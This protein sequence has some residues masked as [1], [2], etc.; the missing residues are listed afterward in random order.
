MTNSI[1]FHC[2]IKVFDQS[3]DELTVFVL[4]P[5][6]NQTRSAREWIKDYIRDNCEE[7]VFPLLGIKGVG[8]WEA[9]FVGTIHST[10]SGCLYQEHD[11]TIELEKW[12]TQ[13]LPSEMFETAEDTNLLAQPWIK[14]LLVKRFEDNLAR[15]PLDGRSHPVTQDQYDEAKKALEQPDN[16]VRLFGYKLIPGDN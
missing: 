14:T 5:L 7:E 9:V 4:E 6:D 2:R 16:D 10:T 12:R 1:Q 8:G 15:V 11:E 3:L 13:R